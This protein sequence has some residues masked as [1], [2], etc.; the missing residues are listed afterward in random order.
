[1]DRTSPTATYGDSA[2]GSCF[3]RGEL[4]PYLDARLGPEPLGSLTAAGLGQRLRGTPG[5]AQVGAPRPAHGRRAREHLRRRGAL[6][7]RLHP[8]RTA[9]SLD[10]DELARLHRAIRRVLRKAVSSARARRSA[11][12]RF[13]TA[14]TA[15]CRTSSVPT[16]AA[17]SRATAAGR[18]SSGSSS[19][20][21]RRR[22]ARAARGCPAELGR[23]VARR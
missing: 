22:S 5:P 14:P 18:R 20:G 6:V 17:E 23:I 1:M 13:P 12:T 10:G 2:P 11:T 16:G 4:A 21:A 3:E 8:L 19:A 15:R 7:E 9:G